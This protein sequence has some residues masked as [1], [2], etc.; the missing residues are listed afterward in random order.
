MGER[1][2]DP[3]LDELAAHLAKHPAATMQELAVAVGC[4]RSTLHR[5]YPRRDDLIDAITE[6]ALSAL[7]EVWAR[8]DAD[9]W[10]ADA[11]DNAASTVSG[12]VTDLIDLGPYLLVIVRATLMTL[13][14]SPDIAA[15][16]A[17]LEAAFRRGHRTGA[18]DP[19]LSAS[20]LVESLHALVYTAWEQVAAG[21]LA[22]RDAA[23]SV[24][25]MWAQGATGSRQQR[26]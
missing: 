18:L 1:V 17:E 9:R 13:S 11:A 4:S 8:H 14:P 3:S 2:D 15:M 25:T 19:D 6:R 23:R 5:R 16:D 22:P 7:G 12:Y 21:R 24:I 10:F 20:W 26:S